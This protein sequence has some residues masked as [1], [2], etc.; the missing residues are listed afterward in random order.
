MLHNNSHKK[1]GNRKA[2]LS[3]DD[4]SKS[5][6]AE[7]LLSW[8]FSECAHNRLLQDPASSLQ[9]PVELEGWGG[10]HSTLFLFVEAI[11]LT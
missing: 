8:L 6:N 5:L 9:L 10:V 7:S 4:L 11:T 3:L 2:N 1:I